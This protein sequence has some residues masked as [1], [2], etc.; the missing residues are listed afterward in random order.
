VVSGPPAV[1]PGGSGLFQAAFTPPPGGQPIEIR[2][3]AFEGATV[4][5]Y[6]A[7]LVKDG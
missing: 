7:Q 1:A 3:A 6:S 4:H 2:V 5:V